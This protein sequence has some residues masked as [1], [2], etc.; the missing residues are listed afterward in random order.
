MA[1]ALVLHLRADRPSVLTD[2]LARYTPLSV[3]W[4]EDV[5]IC[6]VAR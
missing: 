6:A 1:I 5:D 3:L 4:A 2:V